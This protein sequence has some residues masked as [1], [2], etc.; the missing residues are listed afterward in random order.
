MR[1]CVKPVDSGRFWWS[2]PLPLGT[3]AVLYCSQL[4]PT[5][6][7][8]AMAEICS[9]I[10]LSYNVKANRRAYW[11]SNALSPSLTSCSVFST[12]TT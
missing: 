2:D 12:L 1:K 8:S 9:P 3:R 7:P 11:T 4:L 6:K 10:P 5:V